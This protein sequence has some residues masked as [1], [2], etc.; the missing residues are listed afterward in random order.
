MTGI[1]LLSFLFVKESFISFEVQLCY[2]TLLP[3]LLIQSVM[4]YDFGTCVLSGG[5]CPDIQVL[6][7]SVTGCF[8]LRFIS[9]EVQLCYVTLLHD[10]FFERI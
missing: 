4:N 2:V 1:S 10:S 3:D 7:F 6:T 8:V 5:C 9:F